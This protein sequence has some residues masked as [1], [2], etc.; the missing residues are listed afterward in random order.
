[1]SRTGHTVDFGYR[2]AALRLGPLSARFPLRVMLVSVLLL[3][4]ALGAAVVSLRFGEYPLTVE[5]VRAALAG[6]GDE[7]H[8]LIVLEWRLPISVAAVAFG[9]V[10]GLGGAIFQSLTR[11]PL[12]SPDVIGFDTGTYTAVVVAILVIGTT[13]YWMLAGAAVAGGIATALL[14]Y[15]LAWRRGIQS[16][17]LI[18]VGIGVSAIL[19]S[20]NAYLVSRAKLEDAMVVGFWGA[21]SIRRVTWDSMVPALLATGVIVVSALALAP[22]LRRFELGDDSAVTLGTRV[23][24]S[25]LGLIVVGI[26]GSALVTAAAGPIGFI[27]LVAPQMARRL[28]RSAEV[29]LVAAASMGAAL[30][31]AAHL[32]SLILAQYFRPIPVGLITISLGGMYLIWLLIREARRQGGLL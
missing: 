6:E 20:A 3:A 18:I 32:L 11:N 25:R 19:G 17:R 12:G 28:T 22:T 13:N 15:V 27:A 5:E 21:G 10:L 4:L 23:N 24:G 2:L 9:V 30:L 7:F 29:S 16:F 31:A 26:S 1:M 14:V 8:R